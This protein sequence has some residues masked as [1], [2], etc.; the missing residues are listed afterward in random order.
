[1]FAL[2]CLLHVP[3]ADLPSALRAAHDVL[4]P[5]GMFFLGQYG[6][7]QFQGINPRDDY[8]PKRYFSFLPDSEL[9]R[10]VAVDFT[11]VDFTIVELPRQEPG[12][13][14]QLLTLRR[15]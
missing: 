9:H 8:E 3:P 4:V 12:F 11:L 2:N 6:G 13:H 14:V 15:P 5:G 1:M 7:I 10:M